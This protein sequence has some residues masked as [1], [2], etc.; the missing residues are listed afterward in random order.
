M[1]K[2]SGKNGIFL[3]LRLDFLGISCFRGLWR[4][5]KR[6]FSGVFATLGRESPMPP[7][8]TTV[9]PRARSIAAST[10]STARQR[11]ASFQAN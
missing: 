7:G 11:A 9:S 3:G 6:L 10:N 8:Q 4:P 1:G 2:I 5:K